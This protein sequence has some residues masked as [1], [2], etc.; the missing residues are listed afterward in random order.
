M[1]QQAVTR[2]T[3]AAE[4]EVGE[5]EAAVEE[6]DYENL[7]EEEEEVTR[8]ELRKRH[9]AALTLTFSAVPASQHHSFA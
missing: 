3:D 1:S 6:A 9:S 5:E 4:Q 7:S 2:S 8:A